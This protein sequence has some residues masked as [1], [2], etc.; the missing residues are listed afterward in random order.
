MDENDN[1]QVVLDSP[2]G[3][4]VEYHKGDPED[5]VLAFVPLHYDVDF[6]NQVKLTSGCYRAPLVL[7]SCP[8]EVPNCDSTV[9]CHVARPT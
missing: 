2:N 7:W 6:T 4:Y 1:P 9:C 5:Y 3:P 8:S